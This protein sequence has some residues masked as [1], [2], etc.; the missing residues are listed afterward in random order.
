LAQRLLFEATDHASEAILVARPQGDLYGN[1]P[2]KS[3]TVL[4]IIDVINDLEFPEGEQLLGQMLPMAR[5]LAGLKQAAR[6]ASV[7]VVYV[8]DNF[9]RWRSDFN[10][11]IDHCLQDGTRGE[12][13]VELL[14]PGN[15]DYFMLKPKQ[16]GFSATPLELM[17]DHF[18]A[19][20]VIIAGV[21]TH[22][23]VLFTAVDAYQRG[24]KIIVP[25]DCVA[26][27]TSYETEIA[28]QVMELRMEAETRPWREIN[29]RALA[30]PAVKF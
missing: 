8:N 2:E 11:Q 10:A 22:I 26:A 7:P 19:K 18:G 9:G 4:L 17:L 24:Y 13:V 6:Q 1:A 14:K 23:C 12:Q 3:H 16:S 15:D 29:W 27:N 30:K 5:E 28:L 21:A 20:A 25:R